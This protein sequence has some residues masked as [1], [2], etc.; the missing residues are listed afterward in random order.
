MKSKKNLDVEI[1]RLKVLKSDLELAEE[2]LKEGN[3][4]LKFRLSF[5]RQKV[6]ESQIEKFDSIFFPHLVPKK[7]NSTDLKVVNESTEVSTEVDD[8]SQPK[9]VTEKPRW[10]KK[11]YRETVTRTHP[12]K[13]QNF[14]VAEIKNKYLKIYLD[15][16]DAWNQDKDGYLIVC[17]SEASVE[18]EHEDAVKM[19]AKDFKEASKEIQGYKNQTGY[20]WFH[21]A[22]EIKEVFL[23]NYLKQVGFEFTKEKIKEV[24]RR[25]PNRKPGERPEK[26]I[27]R[28][29]SV[30]RAKK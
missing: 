3:S 29:R 8:E 21:L 16:I 9:K 5:F 26:M 19:I 4:D 25:V 7:N 15:T 17:A 22:E 10:L 1:M 30:L 28:K 18:I 11:V 14:D 24:L 2:Q 27:N 23:E 20:Q 12:D 6:S 13:F